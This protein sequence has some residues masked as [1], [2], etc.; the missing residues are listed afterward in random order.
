MGVYINEEQEN[1][2]L[3]HLSFENMKNN[4]A[5]NYEDASDENNEI[6]FMREGGSGSWKKVLTPE[7]VKR[8]ESWT[9]NWLE[10][11]DC[12]LYN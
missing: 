12:N 5:V 6:K 11:T 3:K 7:Q 9:E 8:F 4:N 2:L 10:R 1:K